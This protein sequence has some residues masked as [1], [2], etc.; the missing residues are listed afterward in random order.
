MYDSGTS[1]ILLALG[2]VMSVFVQSRK[3]M[4]PVVQLFPKLVTFPKIDFVKCIR[5]VWCLF[6]LLSVLF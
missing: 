6:A 5:V 4:L 1:L 2:R 3:L